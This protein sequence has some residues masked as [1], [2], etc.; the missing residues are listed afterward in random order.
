MSFIFT[1][2]TQQRFHI[3]NFTEFDQLSKF[4]PPPPP[5]AHLRFAPLLGFL[6]NF[7]KNEFYFQN[8]HIKKVPYTK[9]H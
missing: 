6:S 4:T 2:F 8:L 9:F 5:G 3:P 1:I 7:I